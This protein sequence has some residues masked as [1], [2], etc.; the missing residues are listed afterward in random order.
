MELDAVAEPQSLLSWA[1]MGLG[2][3][4]LTLLLLAALS[5]FVLALIIVTRGKGGMASTALLFIIPLPFLIGIF[6]TL[7]GSIH[8]FTI[9]AMSEAAPKPAEIA[10]GISLAL[11]APLVGLLLMVP[12]YAVAVLGS[13]VRSLRAGQDSA[14]GH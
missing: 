6:A 2:P 4:Y 14:K 8:S 9:I 1:F 13:L 7:Q 5:S 3:I 11:V 10:Q 12:A